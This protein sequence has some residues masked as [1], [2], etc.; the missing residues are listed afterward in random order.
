MVNEARIF[1]LP[2]RHNAEKRVALRTREW[3][4]SLISSQKTAL[5]VAMV[6]LS[7]DRLVKSNA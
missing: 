4:P 2:I 6:G 3:H 1:I 7:A 5:N